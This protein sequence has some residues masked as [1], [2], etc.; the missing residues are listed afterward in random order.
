[1]LQQVISNNH[2]TWKVAGIDTNNSGWSQSSLASFLI[3]SQTTRGKAALIETIQRQGNEPP[4]HS[5][6]EADETFYVM[7][8]Q[9]TFYVEGETIS[10]PA[11]TSVFIERGKEHSFTVDT[12]TAN[13]LV[14]LTAA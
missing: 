3:S 8:G 6:A 7:A 13:I 11:G 2:M 5:H 1:M 12:A 9:M 10:A 4:R 14:L